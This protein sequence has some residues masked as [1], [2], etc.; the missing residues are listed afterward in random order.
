MFFKFWFLGV[1]VGG[2][3][4]DSTPWVRPWVGVVGEC[5]ATASLPPG[6]S[7]GNHCIT[8]RT[9]ESYISIC[10]YTDVHL[11]ELWGDIT[12]LGQKEI[13]GKIGQPDVEETSV[14]R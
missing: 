10:A 3:Q 2:Q 12:L 11:M 1:W 5:H 8:R 9:G 7:P 4:P 6:N 13:N 14:G